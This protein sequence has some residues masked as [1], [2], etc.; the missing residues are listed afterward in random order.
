MKSFMRKDGEHQ[1]EAC[2]IE[3]VER[4]DSTDS[5]DINGGEVSVTSNLIGELVDP[6]L[7]YVIDHHDHLLLT[8]GEFAERYDELPEADKE[9]SLLDLLDRSVPVIKSVLSDYTLADLDNLKTAETNG[10]TRT[11]VI[12]AIDNEI[13][14][15]SELIE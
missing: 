5:F 10:K 11:S 3:T 2:V 7:I 13:A 4:N 14:K 8:P 6:G 12:D 1:V 9:P 15:L